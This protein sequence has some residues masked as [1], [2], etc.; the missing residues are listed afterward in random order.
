MS[1]QI[2]GIPANSQ[3]GS[4]VTDPRYGGS[5]GSISREHVVAP[6]PDPTRLVNHDASMWAGGVRN[7]IQQPEGSSRHQVLADS[8]PPAT[9]W[10]PPTQYQVG[11]V[12]GPRPVGWLPPREEHE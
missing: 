8:A 5:G 11:D 1:D 2:V 4:V 7:V 9:R 3:N 12:D 6:P 10:Q